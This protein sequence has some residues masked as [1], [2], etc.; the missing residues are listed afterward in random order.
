MQDYTTAAED[1]LSA[2]N[3]ISSGNYTAAV[4]LMV[5]QGGTLFSIAT[6]RLGDGVK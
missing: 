6:S 3:D 4:P 2:I 1:E 5:E